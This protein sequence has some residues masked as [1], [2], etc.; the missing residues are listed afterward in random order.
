MRIAVGL[1]FAMH[2][3]Q[4]LFGFPAGGPGG[5]HGFNFTTLFGWSGIIEFFCGALIFL[6]LFTRAAAFVASGEMAFAYFMVHA[7]QG[8]WPIVNHGEPA[9]VY[10]FVFFYLSGS[11]GGAYSLDRLLGIAKPPET[12]PPAPP[13]AQ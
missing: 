10:C 13:A 12:A 9:V 3:S 5:G 2:G 7:K 11:G 6:G 1:L 8:L 4:K